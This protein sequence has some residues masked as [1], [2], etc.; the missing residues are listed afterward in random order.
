MHIVHLKLLKHKILCLSSLLCF[1][2][3]E[4]RRIWF[5]Y[6]LFRRILGR[7]SENNPYFPL[8]FPNHIMYTEVAVVNCG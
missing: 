1:L 6:R 8:A 5:F 4:S 7:F 2:E 3:V